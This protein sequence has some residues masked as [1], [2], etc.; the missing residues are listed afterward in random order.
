MSRDITSAE[1]SSSGE[2]RKERICL[3]SPQV[4]GFF[5]EGIDMGKY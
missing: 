3:R 1:I 5:R 2:L 4:L